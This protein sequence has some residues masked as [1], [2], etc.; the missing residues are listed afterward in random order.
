[1]VAQSFSSCFIAENLIEICVIGSIRDITYGYIV[2]SGKL[3]I[4][5]FNYLC[6]FLTQYQIENE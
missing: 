6:L 4:K 5:F 2:I 1:M 3:Q